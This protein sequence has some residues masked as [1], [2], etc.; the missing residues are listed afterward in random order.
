VPVAA[1][2]PLDAVADAYEHFTG[3][4]KHGKIVVTMR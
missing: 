4:G 3:G 1:T 2:Y